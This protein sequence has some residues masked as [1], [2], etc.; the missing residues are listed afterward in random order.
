MQLT[1]RSTS[2]PSIR[3]TAPLRSRM[4][5]VKRLA[6]VG[7]TYPCFNGV[8]LRWT[9]LVAHVTGLD[10][11][12]DLRT[13]KAKFPPSYLVYFFKVSIEHCCI[14]SISAHAPEADTPDGRRQ[15]S[16]GSKTPFWRSPTDRKSTRL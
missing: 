12:P 10:E 8:S 1:T 16:F 9:P 6:S 3:S 15:V 4:T 14:G 2:R 5:R 7:I 13:R 11:T